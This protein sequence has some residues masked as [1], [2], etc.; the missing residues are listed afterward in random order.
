MR[1]LSTIDLEH[2]VKHVDIDGLQRHVE[3]ITFLNLREEDLRLMTDPHVI[4]L[5]RIAQLMIEYLIHA[6]EQLALNL[7]RISTKYT[8]QKRALTRKRRELAELLQSTRHLEA[9]VSSK[10]KGVAT[11]EKMLQDVHAARGAAEPI[12][13]PVSVPLVASPATECSSKV[14]FYVTGP[15]GLTVECSSDGE[16]NTTTVEELVGQIGSSLCLPGSRGI[17]EMKLV[18]RGRILQPDLLISSLRLRSGDSLVA[19]IPP[20]IPPTV[21]AAV[22]KA[23]ISIAELKDMF[24]Q[25]SESLREVAVEIRQGWESAVKALVPVP[26]QSNFSKERSAEEIE[27]QVFEKMDDRWGKL[28]TAMRTQLDQQLSLYT[29]HLQELSRGG[30]HHMH[31]GDMESDDEAGLDSEGVNN[32]RSLT[33]IEETVK[34]TYSA[35]A[36]MKDAHFRQSIEMAELKKLFSV[37]SAPNEVERLDHRGVESDAMIAD[38]VPEASVRG[39]DDSEVVE[40]HMADLSMSVE[41]EAAAVESK[42]KESAL[43]PLEI[44]F[45]VVLPIKA[46]IAVLEDPV[47]ESFDSTTLELVGDVCVVFPAVFNHDIRGIIK[48]EESFSIT[49]PR[50]MTSD[51]LIF[52][53]RRAIAD[54]AT[55]SLQRV[56]LNLRGKVVTLGVDVDAATTPVDLARLALAGE[57][58]IKL[59]TGNTM[60]DAQIDN[61]VEEW[62][63]SQ[64]RPE[65]NNQYDRDMGLTDAEDEEKMMGEM[66]SS[67]GAAL[68]DL[69][70]LNGL[71]NEDLQRR[72]RFFSILGVG[73]YISYPRPPVLPFFTRQMRSLHSTASTLPRST[74]DTLMG[75]RR[76]TIEALSGMSSDRDSDTDE[77]DNILLSIIRQKG[78]QGISSIIREGGAE[79]EEDDEEEVELEEEEIGVDG[80]ESMTERSYGAAAINVSSESKPRYEDSPRASLNF[81]DFVEE[82][83]MRGSTNSSLNLSASM[84]EDTS[85]HK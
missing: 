3:E 80:N 41:I 61:L 74:A 78:D 19:I 69:E 2:V 9:E 57:L 15:N 23:P 79:E 27:L 13:A 17:S 33:V 31:A 22:D 25:Q 18:H 4:K 65:S 10:R 71:S 73:C 46:E 52:E 44:S 64:K 85:H 35:M 63:R 68:T 72:V 26:L 47:D 83:V 6:Q 67:L 36:A 37:S 24:F 1:R 38:T 55:T 11:L 51:D 42:E 59:A 84:E 32:K 60:S 39:R 29:Q 12:A 56:A 54:L 16:V 58:V 28:E 50:D 7:N 53:M 49:L 8:E 5:F 81:D 77:S 45:P 34:G 48:G 62:Q 14:A 75:H 70:G 76:S 20:P 30:H 40:F 66:R 82:R 43:L 21:A